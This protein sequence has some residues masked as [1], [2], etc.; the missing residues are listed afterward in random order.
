MAPVW[1]KAGARLSEKPTS[2]RPS[3]EPRTESTDTNT[4]ASDHREPGN[5]R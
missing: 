3:H 1:L 2:K 4:T 5:E